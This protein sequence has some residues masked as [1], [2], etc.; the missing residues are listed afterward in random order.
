MIIGVEKGGTSALFDTIKNHPE[1][2]GS[3][4]KET[5]FFSTDSNFPD[6]DYREYYMRFPFSLKR[7]VA[8][9]ASPAYLYDLKS[10]KRIQQFD[11]NMKFIVSLRN[12]ANRVLSAWS[13]F[14]NFPQDQYQYERRSFEAMV[15]EEIE[16]FEKNEPESPQGY[17]SKGMYCE[18]L[19]NYY[20]YFDQENFLILENKELIES[21]D[22]SLQKI[23]QF[24]GLHHC[25]IS[26][27]KSFISKHPGKEAT[28]LKELD[29]LSKFFAPFNKQLFELLKKDYQWN[30]EIL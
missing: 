17:L 21:S 5:N 19:I 22:L 15:S 29:I 13:M 20:K 16:K 25:E 4:T 2:V 14:R 18:Q 27:E 10:A 6:P 1:I 3:N 24:V 23:F 26:M 11:P 9:E 28:Y 12:P 30:D 7:F 8:F